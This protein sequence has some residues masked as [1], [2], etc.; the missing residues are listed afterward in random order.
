[1]G[2]FE[3][4]LGSPEATLGCLGAILGRLGGILRHLGGLGGLPGPSWNQFWSSS[5]PWRAPGTCLGADRA[6]GR[7]GHARGPALREGGV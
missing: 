4:F 3:S 1:M 6:S 7:G 5:I 2:S